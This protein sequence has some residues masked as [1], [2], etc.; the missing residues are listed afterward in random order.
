MLLSAHCF[1]STCAVQYC[2]YSSKSHTFLLTFCYDTSTIFEN[3]STSKVTR[4]LLLLYYTTEKCDKRYPSFIVTHDFH[5]CINRNYINFDDLFDLYV[6]QN[7]N[8]AR[9]NWNKSFHNSAVWSKKPSI[10][11]YVKSIF[12]C[13]FSSDCG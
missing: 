9:I 7:G 6:T 11:F 3:T 1:C 4:D 8:V 2:L 13:T 12:K 5:F 10:Q